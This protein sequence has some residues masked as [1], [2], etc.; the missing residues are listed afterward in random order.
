MRHAGEA[1]QSGIRPDVHAAGQPGWCLGAALL[2]AG[3]PDHAVDAMLDSFGG[4]ALPHVLP[5]DRPAAA[6]DLVDAQLARGD[7]EAAEK[8]LAHGEA[9]AAAAATAWAAALTGLARAAVLLARERPEEAVTAAREVATAARD[10]APTASGAGGAAET[11]APLASARGRLVEGRALAAAGD[12]AAA[13]EALSAAEAEFHR[14][15]AI[16]RRD[17]AVRELRR[18]AIASCAPRAGPATAR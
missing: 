2:A 15:G 3:N 4:P 6:A 12:R 13:I 5:A 8:S 10:T 9:A 7:V 14:F 16:R 11:A 1:A 18:L 17:E